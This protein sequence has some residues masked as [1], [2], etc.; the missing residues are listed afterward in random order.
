MCHFC[1]YL[2]TNIAE[3]VQAPL[4]AKATFD[5][6]DVSQRFTTESE[7]IVETNSFFKWLK[8]NI[9]PHYK[10]RTFTSTVLTVKLNTLP[11]QNRL[12]KKGFVKNAVHK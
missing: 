10:T 12:E 2:Q 8:K 3:T 7:A 1:R 9:L 11:L 6:T 4:L 5:S